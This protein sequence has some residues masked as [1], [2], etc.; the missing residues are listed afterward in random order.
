MENRGFWVLGQ[1]P[2]ERLRGSL[3]ELLT[4]G[5]RTEARIIAHLAEVAARRLFLKEGSESLFAYRVGP[6]GLSNSEAFH[7]ITAARIAR[8]FPIVFTL[9]EQ[10]SLHLTAV[11][12][13]R[14]YLTAE[15]HRELLNE[16]THKT[17]WQIQEL[18]ARRFPRANATSGVRKL[19]APRAEATATAPI[20]ERNEALALPPDPAPAPASNNE[21]DPAAAP[22]SQSILRK[23]S[24]PPHHRPELWR[25]N[26][27]F[28][29][30]QSSN[31]A[32][33][34]A[35]ASSSTRARPSKK[36]RSDCAH[37]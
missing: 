25:A 11:C 36:N 1:V 10:R 2:D 22:F 30:A 13:L 27:P 28:R 7:R 20:L 34:P 18:L 6:L 17:K 8:R 5:Y 26:R 12:L 4:A 9:L 33:N 29:L 21:G 19:P 14:D 23:R 37:C 16:A 15:N 24:Q 31:R 32:L 3:R 35:T